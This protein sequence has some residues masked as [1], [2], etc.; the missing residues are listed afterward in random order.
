MLAKGVLAEN[1]DITTSASSR[2]KGKGGLHVMNE[3]RV[4]PSVSGSLSFGSSE[5]KSETAISDDHYSGSYAH[6]LE[7]SDRI[8]APIPD[9]N[10]G[11]SSINE[12]S[13]DAVGDFDSEHNFEPILTYDR[14]EDLQVA[15]IQHSQLTASTPP[16]PGAT[17]KSKNRR[18]PPVYPSAGRRPRG[19]SESTAN[20]ELFKNG[21]SKPAEFLDRDKVA[22]KNADFNEE[23][24]SHDEVQSEGV[25]KKGE[26][27]SYIETLRQKKGKTNIKSN[28]SPQILPISIKQ[29]GT[30]SHKK[31]PSQQL[32]M[33]NKGRAFRHGHVTVKPRTRLLASE[34]D[35]GELPDATLFHSSQKTKVPVHPDADVIAASERFTQLAKQNSRNNGDLGRINSVLSVRPHY[36]TGMRLFIANPD[37]DDE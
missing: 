17:H 24:S 28:P 14:R 23:K 6:E 12:E 13:Q 2:F 5:H 35:D 1:K 9:F 27:C 11:T 36:G 3:D 20:P 18:P 4:S 21:I 26:K 7:Y 37:S 25:I 31:I 22:V 29:N 16:V 8:V 32:R 33:S 19:L 10:S 30:I 15:P 34:I